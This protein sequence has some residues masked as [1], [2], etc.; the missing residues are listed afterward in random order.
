MANRLA[1]EALIG[2]QP[3]EHTLIC[4]K[5]SSEKGRIRFKFFSGGYDQ[6]DDERGIVLLYQ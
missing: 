1:P 2:R 6:T 4:A 3:R 5:S